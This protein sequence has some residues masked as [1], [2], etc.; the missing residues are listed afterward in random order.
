MT[1]IYG[2]KLNKIHECNLLQN[3]LNLP[4]GTKNQKKYYSPIIKG[5]MNIQKGKGKFKNYWVLFDNG[6]SYTIV[7][8]IL[9]T[10]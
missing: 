10:N 2:N 5:Y 3:V 6:C 9:I 7:I 4:K 1:C 8:G